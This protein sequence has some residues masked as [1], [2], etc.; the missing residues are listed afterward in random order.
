MRPGNNKYANIRSMNFTDFKKTWS[1]VKYHATDTKV[2]LLIP[3][4]QLPWKEKQVLLQC[5][6]MPAAY[7]YNCI[8][9]ICFVEIQMKNQTSKTKAAVIWKVT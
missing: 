1:A 4:I 2:S 5:V 3:E 8:L 9:K 6:S 7:F